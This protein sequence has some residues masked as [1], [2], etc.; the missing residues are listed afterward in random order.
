MLKLSLPQSLPVSPGLEAQL[1]LGSRRDSPVAAPEV[2]AAP[3]HRL[4]V[5]ELPG[6]LS[7]LPAVGTHPVPGNFREGSGS[8]FV[9]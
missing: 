7:W 1:G 4:Q 2:R 6:L 5:S 8:A 9:P 3:V